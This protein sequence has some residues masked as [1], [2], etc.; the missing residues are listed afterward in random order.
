MTMLITRILWKSTGINKDHLQVSKMQGVNICVALLLL[1]QPCISMIPTLPPAPAKGIKNNYSLFKDIFNAYF[2]TRN[3]E[4]CVGMVSSSEL[5]EARVSYSTW[6]NTCWYQRGD[7]WHPLRQWQGVLHQH[8]HVLHC[9]VAG[10]QDMD[11]QHSG[12]WYVV[13]CVF[14][15]SQWSMDSKCFY[16]QPQEL[17]KFASSQKIGR[18]QNNQ[19]VLCS[20][21]HCRK[22]IGEI[23]SNLF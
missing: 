22:F 11:K 9:D 17:L 6:S 18:W 2:C 15:V 12:A 3:A 1:L 21:D 20:T 10:K 14:G 5:P 16:L 4:M 8:V 19:I 23:K 7:P 13:S